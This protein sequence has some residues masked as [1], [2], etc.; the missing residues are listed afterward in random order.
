MILAGGLN[1][2]NAARALEIARP[3]ALDV[4]SG[5][6]AAP[7]IKDADKID[8]FFQ[9]IEGHLFSSPS[10]WSTENAGANQI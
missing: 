7:G 10:P 1:A 8:L 2:E 4:S 9:A 6:E 3:S 5:V